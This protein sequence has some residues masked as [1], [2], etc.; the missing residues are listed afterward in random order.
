MKRILISCDRRELGPI[1]NSHRVRP[2]RPEVFIKEA[3][4]N[5][6]IKAGAVPILLPPLPLKILSEQV[7]TELVQDVDGVVISGGSFD[8]DPKHYGQT[9]EARLDRTDEDRTQTELLLAKTVIQMKKP[10]LGICG[11]MQVM[12]VAQG[13]SLI[14]DI[15]TQIKGALEHEQP[16][17]PDEG[18]HLVQF[19]SGYLYRIYGELLRVNSTHHQSVLNP[20]RFTVTGQAPDGVVEAI[21]LD[22][23][24]AV[25][26]QWHPEFL[27]AHL[28]T[29]LVNAS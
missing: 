10:L 4:I 29:A 5:K 26:V 11:G 18:W 21:E 1:P 13:G 2:A 7:L 12:A 20:G 6:I 27:D 3:L 28:F 19:S 25:G 14:Q 24:F 22:G 23:Q 15:R 9:P 17:S 8:I 16:T